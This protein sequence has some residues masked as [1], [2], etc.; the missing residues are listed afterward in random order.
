MAVRVCSLSSRDLPAT[1]MVEPL[2]K[3]AAMAHSAERLAGRAHWSMRNDRSTEDPKK[4]RINVEDDP[5][6]EVKVL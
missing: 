3:L 4:M 1:D 2:N 5:Q 6:Y